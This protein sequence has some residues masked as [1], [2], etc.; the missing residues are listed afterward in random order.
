MEI[1]FSFIFKIVVKPLKIVIKKLSINITADAQSNL[2]PLFFIITTIIRIFFK[3]VSK[4]SI[5]FAT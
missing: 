2:K 3:Y 1:Y 5:N 4:K